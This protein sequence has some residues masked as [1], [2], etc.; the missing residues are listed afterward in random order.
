M[1]DRRPKDLPVFSYLDDIISSV[2]QNPITIITGEPGSGKTT[3]IPQILLDSDIGNTL[4]SSYLKV[5][6]T[7]P[8]RVAAIAMARRVSYERRVRLGNEVRYIIHR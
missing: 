7:Q 6:V 4:N 2:S 8:R 1:S 3:Q 5:A